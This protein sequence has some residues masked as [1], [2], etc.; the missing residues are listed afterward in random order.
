[1]C[2]LCSVATRFQ[3]A[4]EDALSRLDKSCLCQCHARGGAAINTT[5]DLLKIGV[6]VLSGELAAKRGDV[7]GAIAHLEDGVALQEQLNYDEPAPWYSPV[8]QNLGAVLLQAGRPVEAEQIFRDDLAI[9]PN[10]GWSLYGLA[11]S[12]DAQGK[13]AEAQQVR[14]QFR[15]AW[16]HADVT[17]T[18]AR[19]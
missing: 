10:N 15:A 18:S 6:E 4:G 17:L 12:L 1:M 9:Y 5:A 13:T 7:Y 14:A 3:R 11:Q 16:Q 19:F 8:R 2:T